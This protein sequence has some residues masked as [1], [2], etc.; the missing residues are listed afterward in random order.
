MDNQYKEAVAV[1]ERTAELVDLNQRIVDQLKKPQR[2]VEVHFPVSMDNGSTQ[3]FT[4]YRVQHNNWR[5]PYKGGIRFHP[6]VSLDEVQS[7]AFWMTIKTAV[8]NVPFGGGKGGVIVDP[9]LL[10]QKE[11]E[12]L[13]RSYI[14][15]IAP[16]IGPQIDVPAPDVNTNSQIMDWMR[17]EYE[18]IA[19]HPEPAVVTGK[20]VEGGGSQGREEAT[21]LGGAIILREAVK[22]L[23][24]SPTHM[25]VAI[26]GFGN[27]GSWFATHAAKYGFK[28]IAV[29]D[30]KGGVYDPKGLD[31]EAIVTG[32]KNG[33][34]IP[35]VGSGKKVSNEELL[36]LPVDI[37]APAAL[38]GALTKS[39][40]P[41]VKAKLI[42]E[43][44]NGPATKEADELFRK[45][46]L[47]VVPDILANS[48]GVAVS[49]F[50]WYQNIHNERW[51]V[52]RVRRELEKLM[53]KAWEEIR[54]TSRTM[55]SDWR[56]NAYAVA[57]ERLAQSAR[58]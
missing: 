36:T 27:V 23:K 21:G 22:H 32:K 28:I 40:A 15:A 19:G 48:G 13:S 17:D 51:A 30:S 42:L 57:L 58:K 49:Y 45:K 18:R 43:L 14:R 9:K 24:K 33:R 5:G 55:N 53:V 10:S 47:S 3:I 44:A 38:E 2:I 46:R 34:N 35:E 11:L 54:D 20:P 1:L 4:G 26:Q 56:E 8:I 29:S 12:R 25:T 41:K 37:L 16:A 31:V 39:N 7:L 52:D 50:E 6:K